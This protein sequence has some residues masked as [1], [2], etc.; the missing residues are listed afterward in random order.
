MLTRVLSGAAALLLALAGL[1]VAA[2]TASAHEELAASYPETGAVMDFAP[3]QVTLVFTGEVLEQDV[4]IEVLSGEGRDGVDGAV[5]HEG[6]RVTVP[7]AGLDDGYHQ[8]RFSVVAVDG[9]EIS[10]AYDFGVGELEGSRPLGAGTQEGLEA[11]AASS[12]SRGEASAT[13]SAG[14]GLGLMTGVAAALGLLLLGAVAVV[15][16]RRATGL[17]APSGE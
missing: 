16:R 3:G 2:P 11:E 1:L 7:V 4:E 6:T 9:H 15:A 17:D 12:T 8:V 14:P 5:L 13:G 10:G